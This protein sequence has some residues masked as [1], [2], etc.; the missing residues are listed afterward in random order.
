[1]FTFLFA[2]F[3]NIA[4]TN[5]YLNWI[6]KLLVSIKM[7]LFIFF[8][9]IITSPHNNNSPDSLSMREVQLLLSTPYK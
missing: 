5:E 2:P 3:L 8:I 6:T 4:Y 1:M 7:W 9:G